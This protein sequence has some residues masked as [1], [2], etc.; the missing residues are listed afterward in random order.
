LI[1]DR[2]RSRIGRILKRD[3]SRRTRHSALIDVS[4]GRSPRRRTGAM[5][6]FA[7]QGRK[8]ARPKTRCYAMR[9]AMAFWGSV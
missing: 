2:Y 5:M 9:I 3:R 7:K 8:Y 6:E 1:L 4:T